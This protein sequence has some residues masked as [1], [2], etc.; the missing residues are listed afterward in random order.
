MK[1]WQAWLFYFLVLATAAVLREPLL[2]HTG[3]NTLLAIFHYV[4]AV[5]ISGFF[6]FTCLGFVYVLRRSPVWLKKH[7]TLKKEMRSLEDELRKD[8]E[9]TTP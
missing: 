9:D 1:R 8:V 4:I 5:L 2:G 6:Y 3:S 7:R